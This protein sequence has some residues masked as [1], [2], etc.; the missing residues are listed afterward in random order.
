MDLGS[1]ID[2]LTARLRGARGVAAVSDDVR[3]GKEIIVVYV[4]TPKGGV[5]PRVP[6][7]F[8]GFAVVVEG[9]EG[10]EPH[11]SALRSRA[12]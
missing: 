11:S 2:D 3:D 4:T 8:E 6:S 7:T 12:S 10:I 5:P 9:I 1:A